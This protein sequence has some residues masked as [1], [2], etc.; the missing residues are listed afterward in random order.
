MVEWPWWMGFVMWVSRGVAS[1]ERGWGFQLRK[2]G[3]FEGF[4]GFS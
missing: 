1:V 3:G 4:W 2:D